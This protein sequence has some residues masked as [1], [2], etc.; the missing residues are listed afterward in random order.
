MGAFF[1]STKKMDTTKV[2]DVL[3]SRGH[4]DVGIE[5]VGN[6]TLVHASKILVENVNYLSANDLGVNNNDYICG[7]GTYFYNGTYGKEALKKVYEDLDKVLVENP[8]YGHWAFAVRKGNTT[9]VFNDMSGTLRL[10]YYQDGNN[11]IISS[12]IVSVI[13]GIDNPKFDKVRLGAFIASGYGNEIPFVEGVECV[14]PLKYI[15]IEDR[16][17]PKWIDRKEPEIPRITTLDEAVEHCKKLFKEQIDAMKTAIGDEQVGIELTAGLDSRLIASN[18]KNSGMKYNFVNYPLFGPDSEIANLI[19]KGIGKEVHILA[20][21]SAKDEASTRYGEFDFG[22]NYYR[23]YCNNRWQI[24]N[25]IQFSGARGEC[26]DTPDMY[27]DED[28]NM[29]KDPR[30]TSLLPHLCVRN[31]LFPKYK[32][33]YSNYLL[34]LYKSRGF[35]VN[36]P[37]SECEQVRFNQMMAGQFTGDYMYNS[38]VQAHL[39]FYQIYNEY[40]FNHMIMDI[41]FTAKSGR[42]LTLALIKA[43]DA[44]MAS[45]PFVS[46]RRTRMNSVSEVSELPVQYKS[47][48]G[49][50]KILPKFV[51]NFLFG[52]MGRRYDVGR[53]NSV[54]LSV[55]KEVIDVERFC[56]YPNLYSDYLNRLS[57]IEVLRKKFLI[58]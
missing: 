6:A 17:S 32:K 9:Y 43:I 31:E 14:D 38:G 53:L 58:Q 51:L 52:R 2:V 19:A 8:V 23:Q 48:N 28:I 11:I 30:I 47:Y 33:L 57:S 37:M 44:E 26:I 34:D 54:D 40:H 27:S 25:K 56:K 29:M 55:Y 50:K 42:K 10:Y 12:S 46:R 20:N 49:I 41:A 45:Y 22:F 4:K 21:E 36:E 5:T 35:N 15:V 16:K 3:K 18:I 39:Y 13:A 24:K 7:I 1:F